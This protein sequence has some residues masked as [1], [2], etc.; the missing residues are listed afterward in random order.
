MAKVPKNGFFLAGIPIFILVYIFTPFYIVRFTALFLV[1]LI[2]G[3][4]TYSEYLMEHLII[5]RRDRELRGFRYEW[6]E[7]ELMVENRGRFTAFMLAAGDTPGTL[8]VFRDNKKL[9]TL[10]GRSRM[11]LRWQGYC[12]NRGIFTLGPAQLRGADPLGIFPFQVKAEET[13][14]LFVYPAPGF[15]SLKNPGGI[16]LGTLISPNP[17]YEDLTRYRSLREYHSGDE[18]RRINW[19][20][21]ARMGAAASMMVNEYEATMSYPLVIF[22]NLDRY[23]YPLKHRELYIERVIEAAAALCLMAAGERQALGI[24]LYVPGGDENV[25]F[26]P[27]AAFTL[28]PV[29]E[30]LAALELAS[31]DTGG[32]GKGPETGETAV[33]RGSAGALLEKGKYLPYGTRLIYAGPDLTTGDYIFLNTLKKY[34][35]S[36]EYLIIDERSLPPE[37]PGNSRRYQMKEGGYA[38]I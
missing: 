35:L 27:P 1:L 8:P 22:L 13:A 7:V 10:P 14:R 23:E 12:S 6:I 5:S 15:I 2:L 32:P 19:K 37:V 38:I 30:R 29:L 9:C 26:I 25:S 34:H 33:L 18:P 3:S 16:P 36:L 28:I 20:S 24:I 4:R 17:L 11:V 31:R 21:T